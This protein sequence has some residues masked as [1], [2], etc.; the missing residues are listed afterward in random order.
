[1]IELI[2]LQQLKNESPTPELQQAQLTKLVSTFGGISDSEIK[3]TVIAILCLTK[4]LY[5]SG[6]TDVVLNTRIKTLDLAIAHS[7]ENPYTVNL[8]FLEKCL[9]NFK[10]VIFR[11]IQ[12]YFSRLYHIDPELITCLPKIA[13]QQVG[14]KV[15]IKRTPEDPN[16]IIFYVK[17]HQEFCSKSDPDYIAIT[18]DATGKINFKELFIYKLLEYLGYGPKVHFIVDSDISHSR[19]E[20]GVLIAT[21]DQS[22]TKTP[23]QKQKTFKVFRE[24]KAELSDRPIESIDLT[25]RRDIVIIDM[26]SRALL[27]EDVMVN[28]G[29]FGMTSSTTL[30]APLVASNKWRIIDFIPPKLVKARGDDYSYRKHYPGGINIF[31]SFRV[32]N[33][34]HIYDDEELDVINHIL[35]EEHARDLWLPAIERL[36]RGTEHHLPIADA[37]EKAFRDVSQFMK[38][39]AEILRAKPDRMAKRM[40]DLESYKLKI[41]QNFTALAHGAKEYMEAQHTEAS[42]QPT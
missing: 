13:G 42:F 28:Q 34:S 7:R 25:T 29:N 24:I 6:D 22:Y 2:I 1:M 8:E 15:E 40:E 36:S 14:A 20:E 9:A 38:E 19:I 35:T 23:H 27:L 33:I 5:E 18:S 37:V 21:Q 12:T 30:F 31:Y 32:G 10:P 39:N 17:T 41:M 3:H 26:L 16:P 4:M 11:S